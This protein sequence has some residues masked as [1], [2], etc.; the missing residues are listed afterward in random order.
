MTGTDFEC[1]FKPTSI[2]I[3]VVSILCSNYIN[4]TLALPSYLGM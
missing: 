2:M 4:T 1:C 3:V